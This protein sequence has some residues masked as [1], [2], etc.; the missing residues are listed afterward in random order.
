MA[1][2]KNSQ[3]IKSVIQNVARLFGDPAGPW[4]APNELDYKAPVDVPA[5]ATGFRPLDKALGIGGLPH[6]HVTELLEPGVNTISNGAI[7]IAA[8]IAAKVQRQQQVATIIDINHSFDSWHA[9]QCGLIAPNLLITRPDTVLAM[10]N[11]IEKAARNAVLVVVVMGVVPKLLQH[12]E[13]IGRASCRE[14]VKVSV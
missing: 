13:Q 14:R 2:G 8:R 7:T 10:L 3:G 11:A 1:I 6:G 9:E 5:L 12:V 4:S